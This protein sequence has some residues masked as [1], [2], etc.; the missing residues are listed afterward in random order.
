MT[1]VY[2]VLVIRLVKDY[3]L[4]RHIVARE[5]AGDRHLK[6]PRGVWQISSNWHVL[7]SC[8]IQT[9]YYEQAASQ[10]HVEEKL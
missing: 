3:L 6:F 8:A 2:T 7:I 9:P 1:R 10:V 4:Q 5:A